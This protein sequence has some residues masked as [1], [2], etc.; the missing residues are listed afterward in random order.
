M[1]PEMPDVAEADQIKV[2]PL[3]SAVNGTG[4]VGIPEQT[5]WANVVLVRIG[6]R[7]TTKVSLA[8][9]EMPHSFVTVK[10]IGYTPG[11]L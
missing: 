4:T 1:Y 11:A 9:E 2:V 5:V 6:T 8:V 10:D 3:A 7:F